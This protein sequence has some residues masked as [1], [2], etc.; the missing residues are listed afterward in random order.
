VTGNIEC[1]GNLTNPCISEFQVKNPTKFNID[2]Y[3]PNQTK[4]DFIPEVKDYILFYKDGTCK[5]TTITCKCT[6]KDKSK[7]GYTGWLCIDFTNATKKSKT[8]LYNFRFPAYSTTNFRLV[9]FK[10]NPNDNIKWG[11]GFSDNSTQFTLSR[12]FSRI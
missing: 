8:T 3:N 5:N 1:A 10:N 12:F 6:L 7:L 9:G 11:F 2:I 4:L